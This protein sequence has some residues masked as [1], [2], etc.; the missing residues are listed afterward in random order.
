[1]DNPEVFVVLGNK[2]TGKSTLLNTCFKVDF[3][4][5]DSKTHVTVCQ[6]EERTSLESLDIILIDSPGFDTSENNRTSLKKYDGKRVCLIFINN[7]LRSDVSLTDISKSYD[8]KIENVNTYNSFLMSKKA[9]D[10]T[11]FP[12]VKQFEEDLRHS[13]LKSF[14]YKN[15]LVA[16]APSSKTTNEK[17]GNNRSPHYDAKEKLLRRIPRYPFPVPSN[18]KINLESRLKNLMKSMTPQEVQQNRFSGDAR[19]KLNM[20]YLFKDE[21]NV[22]SVVQN[23]VTNANMIQFMQKIYPGWL[24]DIDRMHGHDKNPERLTDETKADVFEAVF[25]ITFKEKKPKL[26]NELLIRFYSFCKSASSLNT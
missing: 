25:E 13:K 24:D 16:V 8:T 15:P 3:P 18:K 22:E 6:R 14:I 26:H 9:H 4:T 17:S 10:M 12:P 11:G 5:G 21:K 7:D 20:A 23:A 19:I 1:M 2:G